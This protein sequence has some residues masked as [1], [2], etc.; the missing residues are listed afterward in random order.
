MDTYWSLDTNRGRCAVRAADPHAAE[1]ILRKWHGLTL[2]VTGSEPVLL[3]ERPGPN[4]MLPIWSERGQEDT[5]FT[6]GRPALLGGGD[7]IRL[8]AL[9][10]GVAPED[11]YQRGVQWATRNGG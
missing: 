6:D 5:H 10:S 3:D 7:F 8:A 2:E 1:A 4:D 11:A 9:G